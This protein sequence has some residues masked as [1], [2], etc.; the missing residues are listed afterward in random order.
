MARLGFAFVIVVAAFVQT[1]LLPRINPLAIDPHLVIVLIVVWTATHGVGEGVIWAGP[2]G[3]L[4]DVLTME[5]LGVNG[6]ALLLAAVVGGLAR[7]RFFQSGILVPMGLALVVSVLSPLVVV[8]LR[9][10]LGDAGPGLGAAVRLL[11]PQALLSMVLVPPAYLLVTLLDRHATEA[12][13]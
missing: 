9:G 4:L 13:Y 1:A 7:R 11:V 8:T 12:R 10:P 3:I 5:T 6:L 2:V